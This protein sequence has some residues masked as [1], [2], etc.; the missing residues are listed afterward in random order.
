MGGAN[1]PASR[2]L[3]AMA[4]VLSTFEEIKAN[5]RSDKITVRKVS[6]PAPLRVRRKV[7]A[8]VEDGPDLHA[9]SVQGLSLSP[10]CTFKTAASAMLHLGSVIRLLLPLLLLPE[11]VNMCW[12]L[13]FAHFAITGGAAWSAEPTQQ[14]AGGVMG[15]SVPL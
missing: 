3:R 8:Q 11:L 5:L 6:L 9:Q 4:S 2:K 1:G 13:L 14:P 15:A 10:A 12:L 7:G